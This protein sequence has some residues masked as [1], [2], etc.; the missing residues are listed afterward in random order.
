MNI[1]LIRSKIHTIRQ[2]QVMLDSDLATLYHVETKVLNLAVK[3]N[4]KRFPP[5]FMFQLTP[6]EWEE[7]RLRLGTSNHG[8]RRYLPNAFTEQGI[9]MLSGV[10][11][12]DRAIEVNIAIMQTFVM[13][14]EFALD[15]REFAERLRQIET[16]FTDI[17]DA[18]RY[19]LERDKQLAEQTERREIG[20]RRSVG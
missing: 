14:R 12:S 3:R 19:L 1:E 10:L 7:L 11:H 5:G 17:Y 9:A 4:S 15:Y 2:Q 20:F 13:V 16:Q 8:G 18:I 6:D